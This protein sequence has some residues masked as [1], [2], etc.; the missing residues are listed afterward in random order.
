MS[1]FEKYMDRYIEAETEIEEK[2]ALIKALKIA[3]KNNNMG[4]MVKCHLK[5][6]YNE[7]FLGHKIEAMN[8]LFWSFRNITEEI[9][10]DDEIYYDLIWNSK[11]ITVLARLL[12]DDKEGIKEIFEWVKNLYE[13]GGQELKPMYGILIDYYCHG[14]DL[15][16]DMEDIFNKWKKVNNEYFDDCD[17]CLKDS[18]IDYY[19]REK[20]YKKAFALAEDFDKEKLSCDE[21]PSLTYAELLYPLLKENKF[22]KASKYC[23]KSYKLCKNNLNL[24]GGIIKIIEYLAIIDIEKAFEIYLEHIDLFNQIDSDY[25][26][27]EFCFASYILF[28]QLSKTSTQLIVPFDKKNEIYNTNVLIN[29]FENKYQET[30]QKFDERNDNNYLSEYF[31][32]KEDCYLNINNIWRK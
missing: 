23:E 2:K 18:E 15:G 16:Y 7:L 10:Y 21:S 20:N 27:L 19:L 1:E 25:G 24:I 32:E 26:M 30:V 13:T 29:H 4:N 14:L 3:E 22:A 28:I 12:Y 11:Y 17:A 6:A 9:L 8:H 31:K 5:L